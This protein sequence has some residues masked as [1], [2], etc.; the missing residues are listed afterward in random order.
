[1]K[2][3]LVYFISSSGE[4]PVGHFIDSLSKPQQVKILR[5]FMHLEEY[6]LQAFIPHVRKLAG[7]PLWEIR[8]LG[9]DNIRVIYVTE[10]GNSILLLHGFLKKTAKTPQKVIQICLKRY[11]DCQSV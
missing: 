5:T 6:G 11:K 7:T 3:R 4:N 8:V 10:K 2:W 9:K 1:M